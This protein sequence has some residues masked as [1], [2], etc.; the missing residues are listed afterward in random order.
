M[1]TR[2]RYPARPHPLPRFTPSLSTRHE[3]TRTGAALQQLSRRSFLGGALI[4]APALAIPAL[5]RPAFARALD[6]AVSVSDWGAKGDGTTDDAAAFQAC[7][8]A[9]PGKRILVPMGKYRISVS[10]K[11]RAAM[12]LDFEPG[13]TLLL[14]TRNMNGIEIGDGTVATRDK[15]FRTVI[16]RPSFNP[17]AG[18]APF[19]SG[20]CIVRNFV[21]F[22]DVS[23][24]TVYGRDGGIAK[25]FNGVHDFRA[26][27]C[28][29]P[30]ATIQYLRN[31]AIHCQGDGTTP[32]R[33]V[34]CNYDNL[35]ATDIRTGIFIDAGCAGIGAY[36]PT[37][38][39]L[40][41]GGYGLHINCTSGP[42]GQNFF[43]D[44]PDI[45]AQATA[46]A[47][48]FLESGGKAIIK[49]GWVG[50]SM[51]FGLKIGAA[52]DSADVS[53]HFVQSKVLIQGPHNSISGGEIVGDAATV[54][55]G[56][57][58]T[59]ANTV[60]ASS[61]KVRQ[62]AGHGI[63]WG[64]TTPSGVLIGALHFANN[65]T[66][67][68]PL[69]GFTPSTMPVIMQGSTDKARSVTAAATLALPITVPFAQVTGA[70]PI[71]TVPVR[72]VG[73]RLTL[74]AGA[75]GMR[76]ESGG[77]LTLPVSPLIIAAFNTV[78][79][80]CDGASWF[81]DGKSF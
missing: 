73:A 9:N 38:Y 74:Q 22:C 51:G 62:W 41:A 68:A 66:D 1:T 45:E 10:L 34:D 54:S 55:D 15:T 32:G 6:P 14:A 40:A 25:L 71:K 60:I 64:G 57:V 39:G 50:A 20:A 19:T 47:A 8:N 80:V 33:T 75:S 24:L 76:L 81:F 3:A 28:D 52:F 21:A 29:T 78:S 49:G 37:I 4:L 69:V 72:G 61:V 63:A 67:I 5:A 59:G 56:L 23:H 11:I 43:I 46:A 7:L 44:T 16:N 35:R 58:I 77:N 27:E 31:T 70:S 13:A 12:T 2:R 42:N 30:K 36:R 53:C 17:A 79:L 65:A 18:V 48:I 26:T